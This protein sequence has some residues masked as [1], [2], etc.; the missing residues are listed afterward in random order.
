MKRGEKR[1]AGAKCK[2]ETC[3]KPYLKEINKKV[4]Q[5]VVEEEIAKALDISVATLNNYKKQFP[6]L[7]E[8]L[9]KDKG[10]DVLQRLINAGIKSATGYFEE[11]EETI[12]VLVG[13]DNEVAK[14]QKVIRKKWNPP[15]PTLNMYYTKFYGKDKGFTGDPLKHELEK[16]KFDF[17]RARASLKDFTDY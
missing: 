16:A 4:R 2:Y 15:N 3:V 12:I 13:D 10:K 7:A 8:A 5:G 14:K 17:E 1:M 11:E 9:S 6:E